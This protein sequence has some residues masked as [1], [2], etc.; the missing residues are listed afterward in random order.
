[1]TSTDRAFVLKGLD[2]SRERLI[3]AVQRLSREQLEYRPA[4]D[5]WSVAENLEHVIVSEQYVLGRVEGLIQEAPDS[6]RH[7]NWEAGMSRW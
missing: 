6:S 1:M 4:A 3:R 7:S 5:R 2:I